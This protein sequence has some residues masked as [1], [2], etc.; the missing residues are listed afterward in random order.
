MYDLGEGTQD[1]RD[2]GVPHPVEARHG[3]PDNTTE[4]NT[5]RWGAICRWGGAALLTTDTVATL[6]LLA[7]GH[8]SAG[9]HPITRQVFGLTILIAGLAATAMLTAG[10]VERQWRPV[11]TLIR[12]AMA[13]ADANADIG[14]ANRAAIE[15]STR[16]VAEAVNTLAGLEK[17]LH[18][19]EA[20]IGQLPDY[21]AIVQDGYRLGRH[22]A[23]L[24]D[25]DQLTDSGG[26]TSR[27]SGPWPP[28]AG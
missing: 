18:A 4:N 28:K 15:T 27:N 24:G 9:G 17:R 21:G 14:D 7:Y 5:R 12:R 3:L 19:I 1:L 10:L 16:L 13:R 11:R 23:G 6:A 8:Y 22:S 2:L 20:T 25:L 26:G